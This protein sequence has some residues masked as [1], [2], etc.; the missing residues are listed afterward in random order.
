VDAPVKSMTHVHCDARPAVTFPAEGRHRPLAG[1]NLYC[2]V[3]EAHGVNNSPDVVTLQ[4]NDRE[5]NPHSNHYTRRPHAVYAR[6]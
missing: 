2:M 5:S 6:L 3:T 1:A 4:W